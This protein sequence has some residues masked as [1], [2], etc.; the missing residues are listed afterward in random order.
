M[1]RAILL[2][3]YGASTT[4]AKARLGKFEEKCRCR[5]P[6]IPIRWAY[7][8]TAIR[9]R[10]AR[11]RQKSDSIP[12][13]LMRL[14]YE[15]YEA[16]AIQPLQTIP[17][18][19]Y[20]EVCQ[21]AAAIQEQVPIKIALGEPLLMPGDNIGLVADA[22]LADLPRERTSCQDIVFMGHGARHPAGILYYNLAES[23]RNKDPRVFV[24]TMNGVNQLEELMPLLTSERVYLLPLL[25]NI[26][27]H[28]VRDMGGAHEASWRSRINAQGHTCEVVLRG[29][30][31]MEH[32]SLF[33][34]DN[35]AKALGIVE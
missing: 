33:W 12:K 26:G 1:K 15:K 8:S 6:G 13:A 30:A 31:E 19:E 23:F 2:A 32:T 21:Q 29:L 14:Y 22:L 7:T 3:A 11:Q 20:E 27:I 35:L 10:I 9:D 18:R 24:G 4:H 16:V 17:G 34:L 25:A 5:F 28:A